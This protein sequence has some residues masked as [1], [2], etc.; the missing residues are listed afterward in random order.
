MRPLRWTLLSIALIACLA[1]PSL[2]HATPAHAA[3]VAPAAQVESP[4]AQP[5]P[6]AD[7]DGYALAQVLS[8]ANACPTASSP[9]PVPQIQCFRCPVGLVSCGLPT[10]RCCRFSGGACCQ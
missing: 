1:I 9:L 8:G 10:C 4:S 2:A 3:T 5:A 7:D 6:G